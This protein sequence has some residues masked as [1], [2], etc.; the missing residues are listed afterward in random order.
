MSVRRLL[1]SCKRLGANPFAAAHE[2]S[3][4]ARSGRFLGGIAG[5]ALPS[6]HGVVL[7][8][9]I[10]LPERYPGSA[11]WASL[12]AYHAVDTGVGAVERDPGPSSRA[13]AKGGRLIPLTVPEDGTLRIR[14]VWKRLNALERALQWS[15]WRR[16]HQSQARRCHDRR[17]STPRLTKYNRSI[18]RAPVM[19]LSPAQLACTFFALDGIPEGSCPYPI[20]GVMP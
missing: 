5:F 16:A 3:G 7:P 18:R 13:A 19:E 12:D 2:P 10:G 6:A 8:Q 11:R 14:I 4:S 9:T 20:V 17:G 15:F 1:G